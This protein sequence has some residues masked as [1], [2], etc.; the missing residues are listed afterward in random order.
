[1]ADKTVWDLY[2]DKKTDKVYVISHHGD[3]Y[4]EWLQLTGNFA[5]LQ[6]KIDR[7]L[8]IVEQLNG[9][10]VEAHELFRTKIS[11]LRLIKEYSTSYSGKDSSALSLFSALKLEIEQSINPV[12]HNDDTDV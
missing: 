5:G 10:K 2:H 7:A 8:E 6:N 3:K 12:G 4:D 11:L 1:M 9:T